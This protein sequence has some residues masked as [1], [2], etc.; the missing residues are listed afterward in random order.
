[1]GFESENWASNDLSRAMSGNSSCF[2]GDL[3]EALSRSFW[4]FLDVGIVASVTNASCIT[5]TDG[6]AA[7]ITWSWTSGKEPVGRD[8]GDLPSKKH[9]TNAH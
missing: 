4:K 3:L 9:Q 6:Q 2:F 8:V 1:M 7:N 5:F